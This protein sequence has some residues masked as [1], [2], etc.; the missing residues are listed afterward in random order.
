MG[1]RKQVVEDSARLRPDASEVF[2][3]VCDNRLALKMAGW[4][5]SFTLKEGLHQA[6]DFVARHPGLYK[7]S[8][9]AV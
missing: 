7:A 4:K 1:C 9:Y 5:P 3:L 6:I 2:Q 8:H